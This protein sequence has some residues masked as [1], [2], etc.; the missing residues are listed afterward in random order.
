MEMGREVKEDFEFYSLFLIWG[1]Y[2]SLK[3]KYPVIRKL[4]KQERR[5][6]LECG[7]WVVRGKGLSVKI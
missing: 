7:L 2:Y 6:L 5:E 1:Y 4:M 3:K